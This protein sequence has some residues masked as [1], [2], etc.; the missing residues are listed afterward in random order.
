MLKVL[1]YHAND[2]VTHHGD[3]ILFLGIAS[4]YL[5]THLEHSESEFS[6][7][8]EWLLPIQQSLTDDEL[9]DYCNKTKPDLLC[10]SHYIW[11]H[12]FLMT[13]LSRVR[14]QV[15][16]NITFVAGGPSIDVNIN[17]DFFQ[18]YS[19]I[20]YAIYGPGEQAFVDLIVSIINRKE[21][22][23]F[24]TSNISWV[25]RK[26]DKVVVA[27][28]KYVPQSK[29]SP[30]LYC[31]ELFSN[32]IK[33]LQNKNI[34]PIVPYELTRGCPYACTFCDW[35]SGFTNKV[36]RRK[37]TYKD[38]IDLFQKLKIKNIFLADANVGQYQED[39]DMIAYFAEKNIRE[40]ANFT[41][42]GNYSK[43][44]KE[45]NL[46]IFHLL[47]RGNLVPE[48]SGV[49]NPA[50]AFTISVQDIHPE[51]LKNV[52]RPDVGWDEHLTMIYE[53]K[54]AFPTRNC[55]IQLIQGLPGQTVK[56]WRATLAETS[57]HD[58]FLHAVINELLPASP[59]ARDKKYQEKWNFKYSTSER[60]QGN[61][62]FRGTFPE[63]CVSFTQQDFVKMTI[64]TLLYSSLNQYK[65]QNTKSFDLEN[66]VD[67]FLRSKNFKELE[68]NLYQNWTVHDKFYFSMDLD[69]NSQ[70]VTACNF[71][72]GS[73]IWNKSV[74]L[75]KLISKRIVNN[76]IV[77]NST[78]HREVSLL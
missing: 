54:E 43:L 62:K 32:I 37:E 28:F 29:V 65:F 52:E 63:S 7:Q 40:G 58:L 21:L 24:N 12:S 76:V 73:N 27:D 49:I 61:Q 31:K 14:N 50:G 45:N 1:F 10:T 36:T 17:N 70:E 55:E 2:T 75:K 59:A 9:I 6:N 22:I 64:L 38:E 19:F 53:L 48:Y 34:N 71:T 5:R 74:F 57:R 69:L 46:K 33:D 78:I 26:K 13:Q 35:N 16:K 67:D 51:I 47:G 25:D 68:N 42:D 3:S 18:Q 44:R 4:L 39:I 77:D 23:A 20:D 56:T 11:N 15:S 66:V 41:L 72:H 60:F 8:V 30:F